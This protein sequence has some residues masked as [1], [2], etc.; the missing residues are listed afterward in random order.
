VRQGRIEL[1]DCGHTGTIQWHAR[2]GQCDLL[3][4]NN[5]PLGVSEDEIYSQLSFPFEPGDIFL[6]YSDGITEARNSAAELFGVNRLERALMGASEL[7][8]AALVQNIRQAVASFS[9]TERLRD[10]LTSVAVRVLACSEIE[11]GSNLDELR[12]ARRFVHDFCRDA[13]GPPLPPD[14]LDALEL[15]VH[16]AACNIMKHAYGGRTDQSIHLDW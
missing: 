16:E 14:S 8:P 1:V 15:A 7:E 11:I 2:T 13:P 12:T 6:F 9:E 5:L 4:S 10:D 3:Q